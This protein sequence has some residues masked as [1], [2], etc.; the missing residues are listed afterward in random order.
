MSTFYLQIAIPVECT[1]N[2]IS[3]GMRRQV[4]VRRGGGEFLGT[5]VVQYKHT[6][7]LCG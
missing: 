7:I 2:R 1:Y 4:R 5:Y 6:V 3:G